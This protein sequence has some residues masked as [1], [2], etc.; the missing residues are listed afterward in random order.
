MTTQGWTLDVVRQPAHQQAV[1][2]VRRAAFAQAQ[3]FRWLDPHA[4]AWSADDS[5]ATV[6]GLWD[7]DGVLGATVRATV[8]PSAQAAQAVIQYAI[9]NLPL[10][11]P[12]LL[13]TR[14]ATHPA[15]QRR[16]GNSL[17]RWAYLAALLHTELRCVV[18]QVYAQAPR[19]RAL[20]E[21]GF[22]LSPL[23]QGWDREAQA[24]TQPLLAWMARERVEAG[25]RA[26]QA[27]AVNAT[28]VQRTDINLP[29]IAASLNE[30][31]RAL[32]PHRELP[33]TEARA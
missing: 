26:I 32:E 13:L 8:L 19:L 6:L 30:Q 24:Q 3:G 4:L 20:R 9:D 1:V 2:A 16:G 21:A 14:A 17:L 31:V 7:A 33:C 23:L 28:A 25:L 12:L 10:P 29:A 11:G 27:N 15:W 22:E 5:S 18:T